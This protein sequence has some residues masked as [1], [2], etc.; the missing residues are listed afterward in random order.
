MAGQAKALSERTRQVISQMVFAIFVPLF[1]AGIGLKVDF[2]KNFD[3]FLVLF[4]TLISM[5]GKFYGA[6]LGVNFTKISKDNRLSIAIAHTPGGSMEILVGLLAF[7]YKLITESVFVA[8]VFGAV[9]TSVALGPWLSY[10]IKKRK[11]ISILEYFSHRNIVAELKS[12]DR[13]KAIQ[14]LCE[15]LGKQEDMPDVETLYTAVLRRENIMGTA[16]EEGVAIPHTRLPLLKRPVIAFGKS[17]AGVE[18]NSPD[19]KPTHFIFLILTPQEED[20]IQVQILALIAKAVSEEETRDAI[21]QAKET[22]E[23]WNILQT[24]FTSHRIIRKS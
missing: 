17:S 5:I 3:L 18:W 10:S 11:E 12:G 1:F 13:D 14:E 4:V 19:G 23:I 22:D 7:E 21:M 6:W 16:I 9:A 2:F 20:D 8:L 24:T 15:L